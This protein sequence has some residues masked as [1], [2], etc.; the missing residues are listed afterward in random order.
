MFAILI[1]ER[2]NQCVLIFI[3]WRIVRLHHTVTEIRET[4]NE[5]LLYRK[6]EGRLSIKNEHPPLHLYHQSERNQLH[7]TFCSDSPIIKV[8]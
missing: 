2:E 5:F 6:V 3:R 4:K 8:N 1:K 7:K